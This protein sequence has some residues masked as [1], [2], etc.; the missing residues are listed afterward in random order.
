MILVHL[1]GATEFVGAVIE[2][3]S[4]AAT[5]LSL[6]TYC[7]GL[8]E[9]VRISSNGSVGIGTASPSKKLEVAGDVLASGDICN[10][11]GACLSSIFQTSVIAGTNPTCPSGQAMIMKA[12]NGTW[13]TVDNA[14]ITAWNKVTCGI[15]MTTDGTPL[16]VNSNHTVKS[17]TDGGGT[18]VG[19]GA[20]NNMCRF[21]SSSCPNTWTMYNGWSTTSARTYHCDIPCATNSCTTSSHSWANNATQEYCF[22]PPPNGAGCGNCTS[23]YA[24]R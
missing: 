5:G 13:Y 22:G 9:K 23:G 19:D 16:L 1:A 20:G 21:N 2:D 10:G 18:V 3:V 17:C 11:A 14:S 4:S 6:G 8:T 12:Y 7:Y 24:S 15:Q